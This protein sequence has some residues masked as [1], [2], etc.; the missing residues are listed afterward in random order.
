MS[1]EN[2]EIIR[3]GMEYFKRTGDAFRGHAGWLKWENTFDSTGS[4]CR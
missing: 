2:V 1:R 3:R 4:M